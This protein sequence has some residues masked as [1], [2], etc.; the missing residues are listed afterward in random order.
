MGERVAAGKRSHFCT[1]TVKDDFFASHCSR[2]CRKQ[3]RN[4]W[5]RM[6]I[7]VGSPNTKSMQPDGERGR[8]RWRRRRRRMEVWKEEVGM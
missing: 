3:Q 4:L 7:D 2:R 6:K 8:Q 5:S 1:A